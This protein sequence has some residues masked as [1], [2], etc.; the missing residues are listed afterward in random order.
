MQNDEEPNDP[1]KIARDTSILHFKRYVMN[2]CK[3]LNIS[4]EDF[5]KELLKEEE[6]NKPLQ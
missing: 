3:E 4:L 5:C 2:V 6:E 1:K